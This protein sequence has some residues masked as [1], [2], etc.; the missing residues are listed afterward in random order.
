[1]LVIRKVRFTLSCCDP[2]LPNYWTASPE[3]RAMIQALSCRPLNRESQASETSVVEA[4]TG[5]VFIQLYR[6]YPCQYDCARASVNLSPVNMIM[7]VFLRLVLCQYDCASVSID[8]CP[9]SM[10]VPGLLSICLLSI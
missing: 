3:Y 1:M 5:D 4:T 8:F 9:V 2:L 6:F 10:I 7:P